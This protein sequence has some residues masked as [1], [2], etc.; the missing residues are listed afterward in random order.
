MFLLA[1]SIPS[2]PPRRTRLTVLTAKPDQETPHVW[3]YTRSYSPALFKVQDFPS[4]GAAAPANPVPAA[5][6]DTAQEAPGAGGPAVAPATG[7]P[8]AAPTAAAPKQS[9]LSAKDVQIELHALKSRVVSLEDERAELR[10]QVQ[11]LAA[12]VHRLLPDDVP[13]PTHT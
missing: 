5:G 9:R 8:A 1:S 12:K 13:Q 3:W 4:E 11:S 2:I 10:L 6:P 7:G